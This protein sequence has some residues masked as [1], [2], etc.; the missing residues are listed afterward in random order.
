[1][2]STAKVRFCCG[3]DETAKQSSSELGP[4]AAARGW[5]STRERGRGVGDRTA[6]F[7][8]VQVSGRKAHVTSA[9][10]L[11]REPGRR[12]KGNLCNHGANQKCLQ[13]QS[14]G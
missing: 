7:A 1:M 4:S 12:P 3:A 5:R 6:G 2:L 11:E 9:R 10:A 8:G 14:R 13:L